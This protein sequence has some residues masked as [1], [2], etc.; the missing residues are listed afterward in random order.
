MKMPGRWTQIF[1]QD[2]SALHFALF[3]NNYYGLGLTGCSE[4]WASTGI[5]DL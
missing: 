2:D 5:G 4:S 3:P 1:P